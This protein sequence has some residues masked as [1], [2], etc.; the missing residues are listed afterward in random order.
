MPEVMQRA[1]VRYVSRPL[2]ASSDM[3]GT[4]FAAILLGR[5]VSLCHSKVYR[6]SLCPKL[7]ILLSM[8]TRPD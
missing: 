1:V 8:S 4:A 5:G 6:N 2:R 3:L 7:V